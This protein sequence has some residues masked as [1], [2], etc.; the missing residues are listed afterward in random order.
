MHRID[1]TL[2]E[3]S[4]KNWEVMATVTVNLHKTHPMEPWGFRL[5]GGKDFS[6]QLNIRK[7]RNFLEAEYLQCHYCSFL[8]TSKEKPIRV[9]WVNSVILVG[10]TPSELLYRH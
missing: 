7:V 5:G 3:F 1:K 6:Q 2:L 4:I 8:F 10:N 9:C